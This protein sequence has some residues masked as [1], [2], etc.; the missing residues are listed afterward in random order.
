MKT[1]V[2]A[3]GS[4]RGGNGKMLQGSAVRSVGVIR[5]AKQLLRLLVFEDT[6]LVLKHFSLEQTLSLVLNPL[7]LD[8]LW[9]ISCPLAEREGRALL[10]A[11]HSR[12]IWHIGA[13][14]RGLVERVGWRET[15]ENG[16]GRDSR[17][18]QGPR[19]PADSVCGRRGKRDYRQGMI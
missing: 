15:D 13:Q 14:S 16:K 10:K 7:E 18:R 4:G 9:E 19:R 3:W 6:H 12:E 11:T 17:S 2:D 8:T 1:S 5:D